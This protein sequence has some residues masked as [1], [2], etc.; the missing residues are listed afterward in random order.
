MVSPF[1]RPRP[2]HG[3]LPTAELNDGRKCK[4]RRVRIGVAKEIKPGER[5]CAL[6]PAGARELTAAGHEVFG[7]GRCRCGVGLFGDSGVL[8]PAGA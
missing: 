8:G 5:R 7:R 4:V 3:T 1:E 2:Q 6:T